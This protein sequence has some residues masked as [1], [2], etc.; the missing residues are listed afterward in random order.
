VTHTHALFVEESQSIPNN[1]VAS[2]GHILGPE[3]AICGGDYFP[4]EAARRHGSA[5]VLALPFLTRAGRRQ[6]EDESAAG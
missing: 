3:R 4:S 2:S 6:K 1:L 5:A